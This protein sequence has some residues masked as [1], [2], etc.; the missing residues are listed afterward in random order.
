MYSGTW[1]AEIGW[2]GEGT[3]EVSSDGTPV[4]GKDR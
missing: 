2:E 4:V 1:P 3:F